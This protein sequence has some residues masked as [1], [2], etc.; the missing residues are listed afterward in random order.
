MNKKV[1]LSCKNMLFRYCS[2]GAFVNDPFFSAG[3]LGK[4]NIFDH[5]GV[6]KFIEQKISELGFSNLLSRKDYSFKEKLKLFDEIIQT[7]ID[8]NDIEVEEDERLLKYDEG[9]WVIDFYK[10]HDYYSREEIIGSM[11]LTGYKK[12]FI[13]YTLKILNK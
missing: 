12:E 2:T 1:H 13:D 5:I 9:R 11:S 7:K 4:F 10:E 3:Y 6:K 8:F